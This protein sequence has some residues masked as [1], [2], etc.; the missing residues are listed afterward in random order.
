MNFISFQNTTGEK[1]LCI[2]SQ[3]FLPD[4]TTAMHPGILSGH[5]GAVDI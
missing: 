2:D 5:F 4:H 1:D 3:Q